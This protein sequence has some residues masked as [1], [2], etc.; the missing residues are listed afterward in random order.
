MRELILAFLAVFMTVANAADRGP[1]T[2]AADHTLPTRG[3]VL[4]QVAALTREIQAEPDQARYRLKRGDAYFQLHDFSR[5]IDDYT[6]AIRLD[7]HLDEAYFGRGLAKG[8]N[9]DIDGGI[10]DL[11]IYLRRHPDSSRGYTK[12]G[13]RYLWKGD[14]THA[15]QDLSRAVQLDPDNAEAHDDLGVVY[16][17]HHK[18]QE[19][20]QHFVAA[21]EIDPTYEKAYQ[22]MAILNYIAGTNTMALL[23]VDSALRLNPDDRDAVLLKSRIL[24]DEGHRARAESLR[25]DALFLPKGNWSEHVPLQ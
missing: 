2:R 19:A 21:L 11:G 10:A 24:A 23:F 5:A 13:V 7:G 3:A 18:Y 14:L 4:R 20:A 25:D 6:A 16:A 8:R 15:G 22:N 17:R 1:A 9:G 12:R